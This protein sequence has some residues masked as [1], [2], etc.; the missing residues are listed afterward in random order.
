M[1]FNKN[2]LDKL[3]NNNQHIKIVDYFETISST[4]RL[5]KVRWSNNKYI[6]TLT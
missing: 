2:I 6:I 5:E 1:F 3:K 4:K